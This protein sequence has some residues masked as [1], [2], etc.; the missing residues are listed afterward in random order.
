MTG[1]TGNEDT[2]ECLRT[3]PYDDLKAAIN[4]T[5]NIFSYQVGF[6]AR[7]IVLGNLNIV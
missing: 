2:L 3:V 1:C 5:P 4:T 7:R 6:V